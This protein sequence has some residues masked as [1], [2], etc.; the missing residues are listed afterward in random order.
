MPP[1]H[2]IIFFLF[3]AHSET[4]TIQ[5][6]SR[7]KQV[8][9]QPPCNNKNVVQDLPT[10]TSVHQSALNDCLET[11]PLKDKKEFDHKFAT[12]LCKLWRNS[13]SCK[14]SITDEFLIKKICETLNLNST[15]KHSSKSME[16]EEKE[17]KAYSFLDNVKQTFAD[18]PKTYIKFIEMMNELQGNSAEMVISKITDIL[19]G[20]PDLLEGF[21]AFLPPTMKPAVANETG[22]GNES[23]QKESINSSKV[24]QKFTPAQGQ[25]FTPVQVKQ[26]KSTYSINKYPTND[27]YNKLSE[28]LGLSFGSI[29]RWF[30]RRRHKEKIQGNFEDGNNTSNEMTSKKPDTELPKEAKDNC[31]QNESIKNAQDTSNSVENSV[32]NEKNDENNAAADGKNTLDCHKCGKRFRQNNKLLRH[33]KSVHEGLK[34]VSCELCGN[35]FA[36]NWNLKNH[37]KK[38]HK[39]EEVQ[40]SSIDQETTVKDKSDRKSD[41][42]SNEKSDESVIQDASVKILKYWVSKK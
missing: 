14:S 13:F 23:A 10:W 5:N 18:Q 37:K 19:K 15:T 42:K 2:T 31:V 36:H 11:F 32:N 7:G 16:N 39:L 12:Q 35:K 9:P 27:E 17:T 4:I 29:R 30:E 33:I 1:I 26:L 20:Y 38:I 22:N 25:K 21:N 8:K 28:L 40:S 24:C 3:L 34:A 6:V 41:E